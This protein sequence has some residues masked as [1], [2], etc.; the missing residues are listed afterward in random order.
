MTEIESFAVLY[1]VLDSI[2]IE[3]EG[4]FDDDFPGLLGDATPS[5]DGSPMDQALLEYWQEQSADR[6]PANPEEGYAAMV[7]FLK[8]WRDVGES[9]TK[10]ITRVIAIL[11]ENRDRYVALWSE[12]VRRSAPSG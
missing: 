3:Y 5:A 7:D 4:L 8:A 2:W 10:E 12:E 11:Q 9:D 6:D 1:R